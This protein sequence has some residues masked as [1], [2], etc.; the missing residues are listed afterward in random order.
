MEISKEKTEFMELRIKDNSDDIKL[1]EQ[2]RLYLKW[3]FENYSK[4]K[5][6]LKSE[7]PDNKILEE[8]L[9]ISLKFKNNNKTIIPKTI[10][11]KME[12]T[13]VSFEVDLNTE[14]NKKTF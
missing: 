8:L 2:M 10:T 12:A 13:A 7:Y 6:D 4:Y 5:N 1:K 11:A 9:E 3:E 14:E